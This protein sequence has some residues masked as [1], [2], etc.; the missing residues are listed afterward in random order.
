M[1]TAVGLDVN[2][3]TLSR[4]ESG[5]IVPPKDKIQKIAELLELN[6]EYVHQCAQLSKKSRNDRKWLSYTGTYELY[7]W[8]FI[9]DGKILKTIINIELDER[10]R[11]I[12]REKISISGSCKSISGKVSVI[13]PNIF[14]IGNGNSDYNENETM[15]FKVPPVRKEW[16]FGI[17]TGISANESYCPTSSRA[18][19]RSQRFT[20]DQLEPEHELIDHFDLPQEIRNFLLDHCGKPMVLSA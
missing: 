20:F 3:A 4:W 1:D 18:V 10:S 6:I 17:S 12:F 13:K 9:S 14:I 2:R 7:Q 15:V 19:L 5:F 16:L 8:T 11:L